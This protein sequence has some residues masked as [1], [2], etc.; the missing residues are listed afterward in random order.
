MPADQRVPPVTESLKCPTCKSAAIDLL[1]RST[2]VMTFR[3]TQC[4]FPCSVELSAIPERVR[5]RVEQ[6]AQHR[7]KGHCG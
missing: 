6:A 4:G 1:I 7:S 5:R 3:C 2:T